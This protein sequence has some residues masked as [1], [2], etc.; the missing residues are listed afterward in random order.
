MN[1]ADRSVFNDPAAGFRRRLV[2]RIL[3]FTHLA[4][5]AGKPLGQYRPSIG[6]LYQQQPSSPAAA[7][8]NVA[9]SETVW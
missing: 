4:L 2:A 8:S 1:R 9:P 6:R 5:L 7:A 3:N